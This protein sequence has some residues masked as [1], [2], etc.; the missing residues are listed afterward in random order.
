MRMELQATRSLV[1]SGLR[2]R[3]VIEQI[4]MTGRTGRTNL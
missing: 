3:G 2:E 1:F 4:G